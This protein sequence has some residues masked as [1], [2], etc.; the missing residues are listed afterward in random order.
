MMAPM[1][2]ASLIG[3]GPMDENRP[4]VNRPRHPYTQPLSADVR[5]SSSKSILD[6]SD[7]MNAPYKKP[8]NLVISSTDSIMED[9]FFSAFDFCCLYFL[10]C[11]FFCQYENEQNIF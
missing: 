6:K 1:T 2:M 11:L 5:G 8:D 3:A 10:C 7:Q 4:A 9:M